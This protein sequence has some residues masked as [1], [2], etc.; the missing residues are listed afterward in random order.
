MTSNYR[1]WRGRDLIISLADAMSFLCEETC[2][3]LL[4]CSQTSI[5]FLSESGDLND[6][7]SVLPTSPP[8]IVTSDLWVTKEYAAPEI[9]SALSHQSSV[10]I[11]AR[12]DIWSLGSIAFYLFSNFPF[13]ISNL[14]QD[15]IQRMV[16]SRFEHKF[17]EQSFLL[18]CL[19][20]DPPCVSMPRHC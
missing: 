14:S 15:H 8:L 5:Y 16:E 3:R 19:Q 1:N 9:V 20:I 10:K 6:S 12:M 2:C 18:S 7:G 17:K 13:R 11:D 4:F